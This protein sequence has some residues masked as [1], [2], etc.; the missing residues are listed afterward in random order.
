MSQPSEDT[1]RGPAPTSDNRRSRL[2]T[3][4]KTWDPVLNYLTLLITAAGGFLA[5]YQYFQNN[6][7][8]RSE[9]AEHGFREAAQAYREVNDKFVD[10]TRQCLEHPKLDCSGTAPADGPEPSVD[11]L[12]Q[13][14]RLDTILVDLL[15]FAHRRY[16]I[17]ADFYYCHFGQTGDRK[18]REEERR[19]RKEEWL[20][21]LA[22]TQAALRR[23]HF[24]HTWC[25]IRPEYSQTFQDFM[26][27]QS[28]SA[29]DKPLCDEPPPRCVDRADAKPCPQPPGTP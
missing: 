20:G 23:R 13:Q 21:W 27:C 18:A 17:Q 6:Q 1:A 5:L 12:A 26:A 4:L 3:W 2:L 11:D 29:E 22:R 19:A 24:R 16:V 10:F 7:S 15:E 14:E 8:E 28:V 25:S 9:A